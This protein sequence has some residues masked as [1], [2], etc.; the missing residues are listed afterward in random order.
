V[1]ADREIAGLWWLPET[2]DNKWLGNLVLQ[3]D[4]SP[5]LEFTGQR[6][7][8]EHTPDTP[9]V[10]HGC[11]QHGNPISLFC[12]SRSV[13]S[14]SAVLSQMIY[15]A[16]YA[17]LGIELPNA[18]AFQV[19]SLILYMQHLYEWVNTSGFNWRESPTESSLSYRRP[20]MLSFTLDNDLVV[21]ICPHFSMR[22]GREWQLEEDTCVRFN[23]R[24]GLGIA[25]CRTLLNAFRSL[26]HF[27]VYR[28]VYP[29]QVL[30]TKEGYGI[31]EGGQYYPHT[32][33]L[34]WALNRKR[35]DSVWRDDHWVFRFSDVQPRFAEFL[36]QWLRYEKQY[37]EALRCYL[38]TIYHSLPP[39]IV[40]LCLTQALEAYHGIRFHS[41]KLQAF[42]R[43]MRELAE[44]NG[45]Q[46][47]GIVDNPVEFASTVCDTRNYYTHHNPKWQAGGRVASG[48]NLM[49]MNEKLRMVFQMCVLADNGI[50]RSR[51]D[52]LRNQLATQIIDYL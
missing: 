42:E 31:G 36:A 49:R 29:L 16:G 39:T 2:P 6:G 9:E 30:C 3:A 50:P 40:H 20:H 19:H 34:C 24:K 10:M 17:I 27:A 13:G 37:D 14:R 32:L 8:D 44:M 25:E 28:P 21:E 33:E 38:A 23:S 46:L 4:K 22:R 1:T 35:T 7:F 11:D 51:F 47:H 43:K 12:L 18:G 5:R 26:V 15:T 45:A 48:A 41:Y 52:Y